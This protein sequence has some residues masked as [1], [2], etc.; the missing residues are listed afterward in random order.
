MK[1][2]CN[3][4]WIVGIFYSSLFVLTLLI[5]VERIP[6]H[7]LTRRFLSLLGSDNAICIVKGAP[8]ITSRMFKNSIVSP[9]IGFKTGGAQDINTFRQGVNNNYLPLPSSITFEGIFS[10]YYFRTD[11]NNKQNCQQ[12]FCPTYSSA[13]VTN[14]FN[15]ESY[16]YYLSVG[17][18]SNIKTKDFKRKKLNLVIVLDI[19]GSMK[20]RIDYISDATYLSVAKKSI[21]SLLKHL[22]DDDRIGIVTFDHNAYIK[23]DLASVSKTD[24]K[25]LSQTILNIRSGGST[26]MDLGYKTAT[27]LFYKEDRESWIKDVEY[28][29]RIIFLTD[30]MPNTGETR[31]GEMFYELKRNAWSKI[32]TTFIGIGVNFNSDLIKRISNVRGANYFSVHSESDFMKRMSSEFEY[33]VTPLVF[34]VKLSLQSTRNI[35]TIDR[36]IGAPK[37]DIASGKILQIDTLFPSATNKRGQGKGGIVLIKLKLNSSDIDPQHIAKLKIMVNYE[38]RNNQVFEN[39]LSVIFVPKQDTFD[40]NGIRKAILLSQYVT[41]IKEWI[42]TE[43]DPKQNNSGWKVNLDKLV[44]SDAY[45]AKFRMFLTYF[46]GEMQQIG[47]DTLK[48]E[49]DIIKKLIGNV[50]TNHENAIQFDEHDVKVDTNNKQKKKNEYTYNKIKYRFIYRK[51]NR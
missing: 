36:V 3:I 12:L 22:N 16:E 18:N 32:Y 13:V 49:I 37:A 45:R 5:L 46:A 39:F 29:N 17:L 33:M 47:D 51:Y 6:Y 7:G 35:Y 20:S 40:N 21:V 42:G 10:D 27:K 34:N 23:K 25:Y 48:Q 19:S 30:A 43:S 14:P 31:A 1:C 28:E 26:N 11:V 15:K 2:C 44:V 4:H 41:L 24:M 38:D 8:A 50:E 9:N